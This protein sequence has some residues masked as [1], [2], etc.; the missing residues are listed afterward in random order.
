MIK[1]SLN[2]TWYVSVSS[3][4]VQIVDCKAKYLLKMCMR[5]TPSPALKCDMVTYY[6]MIRCFTDFI[7]RY[8]WFTS[9]SAGIT[10]PSSVIRCKEIQYSQFITVNIV[11]YPWWLSDPE[12]S[13]KAPFK[14][15][16]SRIPWG[17]CMF[18]QMTFAQREELFSS[19]LMLTV[20]RKSPT[21]TVFVLPLHKW[22][23]SHPWALGC[24]IIWI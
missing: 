5:L 24:L 9:D 16:N 8:T 22:P 7:R 12:M 11:M 21:F 14:Q 13:H 15:G 3:H 2:S 10:A 19:H 6:V 1:G 18:G 20:I 17:F 4:P 23:S